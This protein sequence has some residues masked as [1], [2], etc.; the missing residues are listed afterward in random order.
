MPVEFL[1]VG[2]AI[3]WFLTWPVLY[4]EN[5]L[6]ASLRPVTGSFALA[7][8]LISLLRGALKLLIQDPATQRGTLM[9][10][11]QGII[12]ANSWISH[13]TL[14]PS[15]LL[16]MVLL[17]YLLALRD[18]LALG[19]QRIGLNQFSKALTALGRHG[20]GVTFVQVVL[21]VA[22]QITML[23]SSTDK[24]TVLAQAASRCIGPRH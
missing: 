2:L 23:G 9:K 3:A 5:I 14:P 19:A 15:L 16:V 4:G 1:F 24:V 12:A 20:A 22:A 10:I 13:L 11:E 6:V 21:F 18:Q 17:I 7:F 8:L